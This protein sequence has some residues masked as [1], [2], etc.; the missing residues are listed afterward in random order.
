MVGRWSS[1]DSG[2]YIGSPAGVNPAHL[3]A[4]SKQFLGFFSKPQIVVPL[5]ASSN[6]ALAYAATAPNSF[7]RVPIAGIPG[8]DGNKEYFLV[9]RR[10]GSA[11]TGKKY[12]D[13]L[14]LGTMPEGYLIWHIDDSVA[15]DETRL[16][17]NSVNSGF[18]NFG[19]DLVESDGTG[20]IITTNGKDSDPF[21]GTK[22]KTLFATPLSNSYNGQQTGIALAGFSGGKIVSKKA[23]AADTVD[24]S[25]TINFPNPGGPSYIQRSGASANTITTIVLH[26]TRPPKEFKL[27]IHDLS[28]LLVRDVPENMISA[29]GT[30]T[31]TNKFVFEYDWDGKNDD[32]EAV[33]SGVYL[34]RFKADDVAVKTGK[35]VLVR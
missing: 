7:L 16:Q 26:T 31:S 5:E 27:T 14:P 20:G 9:E 17:N 12:D 15:M 18:P 24:V 25:K 23:F 11:L 32:G 19:I 30:A 28:G 35:L 10:A 1:M 22:G 6:I 13:A 3:D 33:S 8:V 2:I 21:P 29:N 34:Y 4:W